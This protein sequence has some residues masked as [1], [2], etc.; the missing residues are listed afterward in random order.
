[1]LL[2]WGL[3][4]GPGAA[5]VVLDDTGTTLVPPDIAATYTSLLT[6]DAGCADPVDELATDTLVVGGPAEALDFAWQD[7]HLPGSVDPSF[8]VRFA[9]VVGAVAVE[10][11]GLAFVTDAS[12][13]LDIELAAGETC[14]GRL[15]AL[16]MGGTP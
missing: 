12:W 3:G 14:S 15:E 5:D 9:G 7:T 1:M 11:E 6:W 16:Q 8:T 4:C 2:A 13:S 10:G